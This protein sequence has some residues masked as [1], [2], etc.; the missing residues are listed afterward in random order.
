MIDIQFKHFKLNYVSIVQALAQT[1]HHTFHELS[2][3]R[4]EI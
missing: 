4:Q 2:V 3:S 1:L